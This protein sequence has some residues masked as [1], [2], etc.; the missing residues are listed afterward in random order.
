MRYTTKDEPRKRTGGE[1]MSG[2]DQQSEDSTDS[3]GDNSQTGPIIFSNKTARQ[4]LVDE[5]EVITF[6]SSRRTTGSTWW[7][8]SRTGPKQGDCHVE[9]VAGAISPT[10]DEELEPY[11]ELSGFESIEA[12]RDA[13][14]GLNDGI[15][16]TGFL[17]RAT[18]PQDSSGGADT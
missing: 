8:K 5:G 2:R 18:T 9:F 3:A 1:P 12:W 17:Y 13:M 7:R 6:R 11:F 10:D 4:Q 15:P 16:A 14:G